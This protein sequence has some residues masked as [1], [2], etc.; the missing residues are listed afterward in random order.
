MPNCSPK[1]CIN[2]HTTKKNVWVCLFLH[3]FQIQDIVNVFV[4]SKRIFR[5]LISTYL[6]KF[7]I[8]M[9]TCLFFMWI[10][11]FLS[12]PKILWICVGVFW[13][14]SGEEN[15][16]SFTYLFDIHSPSELLPAGWTL[17]IQQVKIIQ[18]TLWSIFRSA[19]WFK[20]VHLL[21][22]VLQKSFPSLLFFLLSS[23]WYFVS[24]EIF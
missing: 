22:D 19:W 1:V 7:Y 17:L 9:A 16:T 2:L 24:I 15:A 20:K 13:G 21:S 12:S 11:C 5:S 14:F 3:T 8:C 18:W 6:S 4:F 10:T 23:S